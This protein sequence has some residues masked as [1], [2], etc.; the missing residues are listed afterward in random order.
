MILSCDRKII[1]DL[2]NETIST[3]EHMKIRRQVPI[4]ETEEVGLMVLF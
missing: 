4:Y 2:R 1:S 3:R